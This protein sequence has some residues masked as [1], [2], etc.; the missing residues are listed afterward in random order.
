LFEKSS[1]FFVR[2]IVWPKLYLEHTAFEWSSAGSTKFSILFSTK[3][4]EIK[5]FSL[6]G[7]LHQASNLLL[8]QIWL[9]LET[10]GKASVPGVTVQIP[11]MKLDRFVGK[12][13]S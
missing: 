2:K 12:Y 7:I 8:L 3:K 5:N 11:V 9:A 6:F 1:E 13:L 4:S 10:F